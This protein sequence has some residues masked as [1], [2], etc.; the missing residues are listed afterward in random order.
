MA[1][2]AAATANCTSESARLASALSRHGVRPGDTVSAM[3]PNVPAMLEAHFG[4]PMLGAVLNAINTRLDAATIAYILE[5]GEAKV[6]ITDREYAAQV[7]PALARLKK[8]PLVIDVDDPLYTGPGERLGKIE[9]EDFIAGGD[10]DFAGHAGH[11]RE[12]RDRAQ[13]HLGHHRQSEGR[14]LSPPRHVPRSGRQHHGVA[15]AAEA[16]LSV[17]AADVPLQR[18]V[19]PVVGH[20]DGRH[21]CLPAAGRSGADLPDDRRAWRHAH[22]RRAD[23]AQHAGERAGR[24]APPLQPHRRHPDRRLAAARQGDQG[25]WRSSASA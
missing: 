15:A 12:Q 19:L 5:H 23:R 22:V 8:P 17:D 11:R 10:P 24:A 7:G 14:G 13:L 18:L 4:V 21:A 2:C 6:L 25:R 3:L 1:N 20:R 16:G 9:Y